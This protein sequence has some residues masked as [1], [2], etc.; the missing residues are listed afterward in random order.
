M[1]HDSTTGRRGIETEI[2]ITPE[3]IKA[4]ALALSEYT[5]AWDSLED[6]AEKIYLRME[7]ARL[8]RSKNYCS[9]L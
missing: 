2:E 3:M 7:D 1:A 4:G 6:G 5:S 8:G 9:R